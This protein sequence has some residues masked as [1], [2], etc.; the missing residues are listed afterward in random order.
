M[1]RTRYD[2]SS[3]CTLSHRSE[4][5]ESTQSGETIHHNHSLRPFSLSSLFGWLSFISLFFQPF[6]LFAPNLCSVLAPNSVVGYHKKRCAF[7]S[8]FHHSAQQMLQ[9][10]FNKPALVK[11][12]RFVCQ[13]GVSSII[14]N[15]SASLPALFPA[16]NRIMHSHSIGANA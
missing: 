4:T 2:A 3:S 9:L 1:V 13:E 6:F 14:R 8:F 10:I 11:S 12:V 5:R 7:I 15:D 16:L